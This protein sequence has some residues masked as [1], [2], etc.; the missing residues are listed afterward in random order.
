MHITLK[1]NTALMIAAQFDSVSVAT[2][3]LRN[4]CDLDITNKMGRN[5]LMICAQYGSSQIAAMLATL[6]SRIDVQDEEGRTAPMYAAAKGETGIVVHLIKYGAN[7]E[8][9]LS[10][11]GQL[12][13]EDDD[14]SQKGTI[15]HARYGEWR[16]PTNAI[17]LL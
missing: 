5:A 15:N 2:E 8:I 9:T 17:D 10:L 3:L 7:L 16:H 12:A 4:H 14:T 11:W 1:G 6:G 13:H